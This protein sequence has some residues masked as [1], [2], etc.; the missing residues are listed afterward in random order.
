MA[1]TLLLRY[2]EPPN[3]QGPRTFV[4]DAVFLKSHF[5]SDGGSHIV[6]KYT[7]R[8]LPLV[9]Q[10]GTVSDSPD[11]P[12]FAVAER[13]RSPPSAPQR[14][15]QPAGLE[16]LLQDA[17]RGILK[18][19]GKIGGGVNQA[20]RDAVGEVR[21]NVQGLQAGRGSPRASSSASSKS[22]TN[23]D[24]LLEKV[25]R[26]EERNRA[27]A[28]MLEGAVAELWDHQKSVSE[29]E[30]AENAD[31]DS[32]NSLNMAIARVQFVQ[33][34]LEDSSM[35]LPED[36]ARAVESAS[37]REM[38][39]PKISAQSLP[40]SP[41]SSHGSEDPGPKHASHFNSEGEKAEHEEISQPDSKPNRS[42][43][44]PKSRHKPK[45]VS[46]TSRHA[47]STTQQIPATAP[48]SQASFSQS[49]T[50]PSSTSTNLNAPRP[51]LAQS[52]FSWMLGDGN[53]RNISFVS[54]SPFPAEK[55]RHAGNSKT[56]FLFGDEDGFE[57]AETKGG[58][59]SKKGDVGG[60]SEVFDLGEMD[61]GGG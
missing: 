53:R 17:A 1:L 22:P 59:K 23:L 25:S 42:P 37:G 40:T 41:N 28:K 30:E 26:L 4:S 6:H 50:Q 60:L 46:T 48:S 18:R 27:L 34:Y 29:A 12:T 49:P 58:S 43:S 32:I 10:A 54:A 16:N 36:D 57:G 47:L 9:S 14:A 38:P 19:G 21:K 3:T 44:P 51:S 39:N 11:I 8:H 20:V 15:S 2:P 13:S 33:V 56:D 45:P 55:R 52:S 5:H 24:M 7:G 61:K 31:G 35:A